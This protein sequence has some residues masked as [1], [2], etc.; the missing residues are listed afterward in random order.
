MAY[1]RKTEDEYEIQGCYQYGW[2]C[3]T[4]EVTYRDAREQ[5][6]TYRANE[7]GVAFKIVHKRVKLNVA[8]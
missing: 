5:I 8:A 6:R 1:V 2:E 7:P 3:V 4:T